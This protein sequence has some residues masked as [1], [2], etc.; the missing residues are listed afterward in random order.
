M[1]GLGRASRVDVFEPPVD[2]RVQPLALLGVEVVR[3]V[4]EHLVEGNELD[5]LAV[6]QIGGLVQQKPATS[7][8]CLERPHGA[9]HLTVSRG[10]YSFGPRPLGAPQMAW[11]MTRSRASSTSK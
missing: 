10:V 6:G 3:A 2:G 11:A 8:V 5:D 1:P 9:A 4:G 7:N